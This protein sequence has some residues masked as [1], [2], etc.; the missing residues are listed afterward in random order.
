MALLSK[1]QW[2][3]L[4]VL[5]VAE[6]HPALHGSGHVGN[7]KS[8]ST[9]DETDDE[10]AVRP[11]CRKS[12]EAHGAPHGSNTNRNPSRKRK[13]QPAQRH[14]DGIIQEFWRILRATARCF[15]GSSYSALRL[16]RYRRFPSGLV[17]RLLAIK[18]IVQETAKASLHE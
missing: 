9:D 17:S 13:E 18:C 11:S 7:R 5:R 2:F 4:G 12:I 6:L 14:P 15:L 10:R 3:D 8:A 1:E 16:Y